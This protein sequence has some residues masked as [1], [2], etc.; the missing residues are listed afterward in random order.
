[1]KATPELKL[2]TQLWSA[3]AS[4]LVA[5]DIAKKLP[6]SL[7]AGAKERLR[8]AIIEVDNVFHITE[9][10]KGLSEA[11]PGEEEA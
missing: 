7:A 6:D 3:R 1:M 4:I 9:V 5:M 11:V 10:S 8:Q 2:E